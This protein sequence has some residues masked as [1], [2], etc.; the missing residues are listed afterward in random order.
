M[1][2][3]KIGFIGLFL[4]SAIASTVVFQNCSKVNYNLPDSAALKSS[5]KVNR[6]ISLNSAF[7]NQNSDLKIL[8]IVDDSYTMSQ[9]QNRLSNAVDS[10]MNPLLGRNVEFKIVSTSGIPSNEI[11]YKID[12]KYLNSG[13]NEITESQALASTSY[14]IEKIISNKVDSR[15][16]KIASLK[17]YTQVQFNTIKAKV[18]SA[19]LNVGV[20][21]SDAEEGLCPVVRQLFDT[22]TTSFFKKGDKAAII[23]LTDEDDSSTFNSCVSKY[24]EQVSNNP[25]IYYNYL[26]QR[27]RLKLE[28]QVTR[29]GLV[30]W[31]PATWAIGL[32]NGQYFNAG[33][34]CNVSDVSIAT[35]KITQKGYIV[36]NVSECI[37]EAAQSTRYGAD[38]GDDGTNINKNLCNSNVIFQGINYSN[39]YSYV[40]ATNLS[41]VAGS[42]Q[43]I[44]QPAN[45][46]AQTGIYTSVIAADTAS[47]NMQD[48]KS[49][50]ITKS[51]ELFGTGFIYASI[52]RKSTESC[53]LQTGQS[54][55]RKYEDLAARLPQNSVVESMCATDFSNVL[56]QI[57]Q[58][59]VS[60]AEKS[61]VVTGLNTG[62]I[63]L[64]VAV[65]RNSQLISLT[66]SQYEIVGNTITLTN[67]TLLSG[68]TLEISIGKN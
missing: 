61:Y 20:N 36:R 25:V 29:D 9:S 21:G 66:N 37:Y 46:I 8:I 59:V 12:K 60:Q 52:I 32:P 51:N 18:K 6:V 31:L 11:D 48:L 64:S 23:F 3:K 2:R 45:T 58:F 39:L 55:G 56:S 14:S 54:Y 68:D 13:S 49:A 50:L 26:E 5:G 7:N 35:T 16:S 41:A 10:L 24:K 43:K 28:Y 38:L 63:I 30:T 42:C 15:H 47:S 22:T 57:S 27:A 40:S 17:E 65:K 67:Y 44:I 34:T 19:I 62:E 4:I 1:E 33:S 53:A